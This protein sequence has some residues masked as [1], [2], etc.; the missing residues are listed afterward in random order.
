MYRSP[1]ADFSRLKGCFNRSLVKFVLKLLYPWLSYGLQMKFTDKWA[2]L[3]IIHQV[4]YRFMYN[5]S[6]RVS[7]LNAENVCKHRYK[8]DTLSMKVIECRRQF[9]IHFQTH[10]IN[11]IFFEQFAD[12]KKSKIYR[13]LFIGLIYKEVLWL[14][15]LAQ[16]PTSTFSTQRVPTISYRLPNRYQ[17]SCDNWHFT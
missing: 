13:F 6:S 16:V 1:A 4:R 11:K 10:F 9:V 12:D 15:S 8:I 17:S 2:Y 3:W 5:D 14:S 7:T